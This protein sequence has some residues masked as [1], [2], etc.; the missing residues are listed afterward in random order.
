M[1]DYKKTLLLPKTTFPMKANLKQREPEMLK[2][3]EEIK[4]YDEMVAA[5]SADDRYVLHDGPPYA[6]GH[7]HMGTALNKVLKDIVVKSRNI[8]GQQAEYVPG[9]DCHGLPIEH[10]VEQEL[11]KKDKE[12]DTLTIRKIC[13]SYASKWLDTQRKR[14][15]AVGRVR[16]VGRS[17][18]D[19]EAGIRGGH[20][21]R[22]GPVHGTRRRGPGQEADLLVLRLPHCP[23]RSRGGIRGPHLPVHL[24][25][26]SHG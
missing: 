5:G 13:R 6:N 18:H 24:R 7:I 1:S 9:W 25:P 3:W 12:L 23:G 4:A 10:K 19:H 22:T 14:V 26:L 11:K 16:R 21:S 17:V 15:Q 20:G 2:F 8:Q